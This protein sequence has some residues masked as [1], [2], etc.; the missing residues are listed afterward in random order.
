MHALWRGG[1]AAALW[2]AALAILSGAGLACAASVDSEAIDSHVRRM[3]ET[4]HVPGAA[5][6]IV[7]KDE[8]LFLGGYGVDAQGTIVTDR[9]PFRLGSMS[10]AFTALVTMRLVEQGTITLDA[11]VSS[12]LPDLAKL[13][14]SG[15]TLADLLHH[16]SGLPTRTPQAG[17]SDPLSKHVD[18]LV[19]VSLVAPPGTRHIYSSANYLVAARMLERASGARFSDLLAR[20]VSAPL[21]LGAQ[22]GTAGHRY[23]T[24]WPIAHRPGEEQGR[25]ATASVTASAQDMAQFLRF[26]LGDGRWTGKV[27]LSTAGMR[28]MHDGAVDGGG[29][30][31]ALGWREGTLRGARA[32]HHGGVLP[33]HQ[34]MMILLPDQGIGIAVL[35]NASSTLPLPTRPTSHRLAADTAGLI[36]GSEPLS[37]WVSFRAWLMVLWTGLAALLLHHGYSTMRILSGRDPAERPLRA[38]SADVAIILALII[39]LPAYL[40]LSLPQF[41]RQ[42]PDIAIWIGVM[43]ALTAVGGLIRIRRWRRT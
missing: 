43:F 14:Q 12:L 36:L 40:G 3:L 1:A 15:A 25:L 30:R 13:G 35:L 21:G 28:R 6:V 2:L 39:G 16:T 23:W 34:G 18:A 24:I 20:E 32:I 22:S 19:D 26:Q 9:K 5:V 8:V 27:L 41:A 10:K 33:E 38:T 42:A 37:F 29:F 17:P 31:Y 4:N 11:Q 7:D